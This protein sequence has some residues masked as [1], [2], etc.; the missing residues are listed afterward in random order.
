MPNCPRCQL[1]LKDETYE[2]TEVLFC[3]TCWGHWVGFGTFKTILQKE[4]YEF[5]ADDAESVLKKWAQQQG[6][7]KLTDKIDCPDCGNEMRQMD[8]DEK[9]PVLVDRCDDHGVW[10]DC[11]EIKEIQVFLDQLRAEG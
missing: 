9:C 3:G 2:G 5:S 6:G 7:E 8:F 4:V 11:A 1:A 10:L